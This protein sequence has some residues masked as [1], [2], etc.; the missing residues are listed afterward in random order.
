MNKPRQKPDNRLEELDGEFVI[1]HPHGNKMFHCNTTASLIWNLCDGNRTKKEIKILLKES[2]PE[3][4]D[5]IEDD[6]EETLKQLLE[7]NAIDMI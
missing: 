2:C 5:S 4:A 1:Y 6:V 7:H 3:E